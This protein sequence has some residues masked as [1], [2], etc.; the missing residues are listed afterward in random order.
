MKPRMQ[1][2]NKT[3]SF[4]DFFGIIIDQACSW[5]NYGVIKDLILLFCTSAKKFLD[6]YEACFKIYAEQ[7]LPKGMKHIEIGDGAR[8]GGKKLVIK[9]DREWGEVTFS[10]FDKLRGTFA[11]ILDVRRSDLYL[12]DIRQGCIEMTFMITEELAGRLFTSRT[13]LTPS[14][15]R[16]LKDE[17]VLS[18]KCESLILLAAYNE[19]DTIRVQVP[20]GICPIASQVKDEGVISVKCERSQ[21][22]LTLFTILK[23]LFPCTINDWNKLSSNIVSYILM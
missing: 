22:I 10:D 15:I 6:E 13:C 4:E 19:S 3:I 9:I 1:E 23:F 5:F 16:S 2:L 11:S 14:Q 7:R 8:K 21:Y 12:A 18:V 20:S 17:G